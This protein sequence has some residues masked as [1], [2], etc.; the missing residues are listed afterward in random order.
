MVAENRLTV[1]SGAP[2]ASPTATS[3]KVSD[4]DGRMLAVAVP[5][6]RTGWP[7]IFSASTSKAVR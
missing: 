3:V 1:I 5:S 7:R 6:T 4:G 2:V